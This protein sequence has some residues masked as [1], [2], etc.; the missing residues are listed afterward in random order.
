MVI[1]RISPPLESKGDELFSFFMSPSI[2]WP[3]RQRMWYCIHHRSRFSTVFLDVW[4]T[5][6][7]KL[8]MNCKEMKALVWHFFLVTNHF[9]IAWSKRSWLTS[10][11][12]AVCPTCYWN[13]HFFN[14]FTTNE[15]IATKF[16][17]DYRHTLQTHSFTQRTY[18][19]S[20]FIAISSLVLEL[21]KKCWV[22]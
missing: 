10:G 21:L 16:E 1:D 18:P 8:Q 11:T 5:Q 6:G 3:K 13:R 15:D 17:A 12:S 2:I 7:R 19:C 20:N 14:N 4:F 22:Q 9:S